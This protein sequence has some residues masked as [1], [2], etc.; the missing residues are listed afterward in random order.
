MRLITRR[1]ALIGSAGTLA[2]ARASALTQ[3]E[4][5]MLFGG[6]PGWVLRAAGQIPVADIDLVNNRTFGGSLGSLLSN[7]RSSGKYA[8]DSSGL[9]HY[10]S[11]NVPAI[12]NLGMS[13]EGSAQ[14]VVLQNRDLTQTSVWTATSITPALNAIGADG[15][16]NSAST[17]TATSANG[18]ILQSITLG[19]SV[20]YQYA[21]VK[22]ISG[23]G[24]VSMTM[25]GGT[26]WT[27]LSLTTSYQQLSIT[28]QTIA[29]P[30]VGF[31]MASSGDVVAV[32]FVQNED[33]NSVTSPIYNQAISN[34]RAAEVCT[35]SGIAAAALNGLNWSM[36]GQVGPTNVAASL[37]PSYYD[38]S[39]GNSVMYAF[40]ST[41]LRS[42]LNGVAYDQPTFGSGSIT[43]S[44][45][46]F[47]QTNNGA[48]GPSALVANG[49]SPAT[50][51]TPFMVTPN[52]ITILSTTGVRLYANT[53]LKRLTIFAPAISNS[54]LQSLAT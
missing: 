39:S 9:L 14:N 33:G 53:T 37:G 4:R 46:K 8:P 27:A 54:I 22:R 20:R 49:G 32:D 51:A 28:S 25:D 2:C 15:S 18:T 52:N 29:N 13:I 17:L 5:L 45:W 48:S 16:A 31:K 21:F 43:S 19:S 42:L 36:I 26:T 40:L 10:F 38:I 12:T 11:S 7:V 30:T 34:I 44:S 1:S 50:N 41:V 35:I 24:A 3:A 47:G 23:S 6:A